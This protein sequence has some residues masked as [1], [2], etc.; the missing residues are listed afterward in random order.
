MTKRPAK[1]IGITYV[2]R[3]LQPFAIAV[4]MDGKRVGTIK[5]EAKPGSNVKPTFDY[6]YLSH[7]PNSPLV[8]RFATIDEVKASIEGK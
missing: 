7:K 4:H 8:P 3:G 2:H 5:R 1:S 6:F